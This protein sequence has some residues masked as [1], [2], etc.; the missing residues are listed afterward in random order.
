[1]AIVKKSSRKEIKDLID[2]IEQYNELLFVIHQRRYIHC[3]TMDAKNGVDFR[4][5]S[6]DPMAFEDLENVALV[7]VLQ[8]KS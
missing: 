6:V 8:T 1:M 7:I 4:K 5:K 2:E 3:K